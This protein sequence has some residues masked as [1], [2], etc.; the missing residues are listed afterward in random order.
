MTPM[1]GRPR[2]EAPSRFAPTLGAT[3]RWFEVSQQTI[4]TWQAIEGC[5]QR[6]EEGYDLRAICRWQAQRDRRAATTVEGKESHEEADRRKKI[7]DADRSEMARDRESGTLLLKTD[8]DADLMALI[9]SFVSG[10]ENLPPKVVPLLTAARGHQEIDQIL[11]DHI[12]ALR[13]QLAA[14]HSPALPAVESK[15]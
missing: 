14:Q 11:R 15:E 6:T 12:R 2:A 4:S 13:I 7:A 3:A 10:L 8:H 9:D 1:V 5:P